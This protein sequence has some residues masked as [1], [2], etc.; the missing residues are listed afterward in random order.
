[1]AKKLIPQKIVIEF[2]DGKFSNGVIIYKVNDDGALTRTRS[3]GLKNA[4]FSKPALNGLLEKFIKHAKKSE[5]I[6]DD[7]S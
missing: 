6:P 1:M 4:T 5:V 3:I 2:M 7:V